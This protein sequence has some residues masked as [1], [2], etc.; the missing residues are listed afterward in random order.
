MSYSGISG[1]Y[2]LIPNNIIKQKYEITRNFE[3]PN[4]IENYH[5]SVLMDSGPDPNFFESDQP[6]KD[7][8]SEEFLNLRHSGGRS[9]ETPDHS[10]AFF[11]LTEK[12]P[13]RADLNPLL[14]QAK[15]HSYSR[16]NYFRFLNTEDHS[17][18]ERELPD[19][20]RISNRVDTFYGMKNRLKIF[21]TSKSA[22][23][24]SKQN[25]NSSTKYNES[26]VS[27]ATQMNEFNN[28]NKATVVSNNVLMG[29]ERT[30]DHEFQ[31]A[32]YSDMTNTGNLT[33]FDSSVKN[34]T[35]LDSQITSFQD[36]RV[37]V[38]LAS[39]MKDIMM[40]QHSRLQ[41]GDM[42]YHIEHFIQ[43][44]VNKVWLNVDKLQNREIMNEQNYNEKY[45]DQNGRSYGNKT[46]ALNKNWESTND[47]V[48]IATFMN[49]INKTTNPK[50]KSQL[51]ETVQSAKTRK[52]FISNISRY[53]G[54]NKAKLGRDWQETSDWK[55]S[56][57]TENL[58]S[59]K[60][61]KYSEVI[62][63]NLDS[64]KYKNESIERLTQKIKNP[65]TKQAEN[66]SYDGQSH[67]ELGTS[68]RLIGKLGSKQV[69]NYT[70]SDSV[71]NSMNDF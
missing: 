58:G 36:Q 7:N 45:E 60:P 2:G 27:F 16:A 8:H 1:Q 69:R 22:F 44:I 38:G 4:Q 12:D 51:I 28:I 3:D 55:E 63:N 33:T 62:R 46:S 21:S 37:S 35:D 26:D 30:T 24:S 66:Q 42:N 9:E 19:A 31:I 56:F 53:V 15:E 48:Q 20:K 5:R 52:E 18:T 49:M 39:T 47:N 70:Q 17:V 14:N 40:E 65:Y 50:L 43:P 13:R 54:P 23:V 34:Q 32:S 41:S 68:D 25:K 71:K 59:K 6:R 57:T 64:E 11:E 61:N 10:E 29:W 67:L